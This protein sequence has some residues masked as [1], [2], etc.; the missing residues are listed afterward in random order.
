MIRAPVTFTIVWIASRISVITRIVPW[1]AGSRFRARSEPVV[2]Q[3]RDVADDSG[4]DGRDRDEQREA[5]EPADEPAVAWADREL[6][7]LEERAGDGVVAGELAEDERDEQHPDDG[8]K[9]SQ[10]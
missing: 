9:V 8:M 2:G 5:V 4:V 1:P 7:V 10:M 3:R 6:A